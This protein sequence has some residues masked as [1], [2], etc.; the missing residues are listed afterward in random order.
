M[1]N[2]YF[3]AEKKMKIALCD[4]NK[5]FRT[6]LYDK[7]LTSKI[8]SD[9][10]F[11][12]F[13]C[14]EDLIES[15]KADNVYSI[16]FLDIE[17]EGLNGIEAAKII[18]EKY[19]ETVIVFVTNYGEY[20]IDA[21]D[22]DACGYLLKD[23]SNDKLDNLLR[24]VVKKVKTTKKHIYLDS[25]NGLVTL[26]PD[27]IYYI[28]YTRRYC[29]YYTN[30]EKYTIKKN[31]SNALSELKDYGFCQVYQCF[32]VNFAKVQAILKEDVVLT[33]DVKVPISRYRKAQILKEYIHYRKEQL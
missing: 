23:F 17:M 28:E 26:F 11:D 3:I 30:S 15:I 4:D 33:N 22:C 8:I 27:D 6:K 32:I 12:K 9:S 21:F 2:L 25:E 16:I 24:K 29:T 31:I 1:K 18:K 14:A 13:S 5:E 20:A 7:L 19:P 10:D